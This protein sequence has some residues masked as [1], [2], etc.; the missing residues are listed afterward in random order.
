MTAVWN[1]LPIDPDDH[2]GSH[3]GTA[4]V[5]AVAGDV[6]LTLS[7]QED[8]IRHLSRMIGWL[9]YMEDAD[10]WYL[11]EEQAPGYHAELAD[12]V[13]ALDQAKHWLEGS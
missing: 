10:Y 12:A 8:L 3:V 5:G 4:G 9:K 7:E 6:S 2:A 1:D 11:A 13:A